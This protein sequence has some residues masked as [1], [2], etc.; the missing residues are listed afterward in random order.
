M[1]L[2]NRL[3]ALKNR[4]LSRRRSRRR[5]LSTPA[6]CEPLEERLLLSVVANSDS[7]SFKHDT[8]H[9]QSA[10][11]VLSN[12]INMGGGTL[13]AVL[14]SGPA[15]AVSFQLNSDGSFT[16]EPKPNSAYSDS[17]SYYATNG[18]S[19][20][21]TATVSLS[22]TNAAPTVQNDSYTVEY[23]TYDTAA[24]GVSGVL[25]NDTDGD[26]DALTAELLTGPAHG[27][28]TLN[29]DGHFI[30]TPD[31]GYEGTDSFE[32]QAGDGVT[33]T[34]G[35][36]T[37]NVSEVFTAQTNLVDRPSAGPNWYGPAG[38]SLLTGQAHTAVAV[39]PGHI[40][41]YDSLAHDPR[42]VV[43]VDVAWNSATTADQIEARLSLG[44]LNGSSVFYSTDGL[45]GGTA[46]RFALQLDA[47]TL[48]SGR[49]DY[50]LTLIAHYTNGATSTRTYTGQYELINRDGSE[51]GAGWMLAELDRLVA[52]TGGMLYVSGTG[53]TGWFGDNGNGTFT[54]PVGPLHSTSLV[55]NAD[56]SY[57]LKDKFGNKQEFNSAGLLTARV[58]T[59]G[60]AISYAWTDA[61]G[62][63][64]ADELSTI[65]DPFSRVTTFSYTAGLVSSVTD[66][67]GRATT[68]GRDAQDRL[69][70]VT[71]P[72]PRLAGRA[73]DELR[74]R[75]RRSDHHHRPAQPRHDGALRLRRPA[76]A[77]HLRRRQHPAVRALSAPGAGGHVLGAGLVEQFRPAVFPRPDDRLDHQ[78]PPADDDLHDGPLRLRY[79]RNQSAGAH[80]RLPAGRQ[81]LPHAAHRTR[82][83]RRRLADR[84][85][86]PIPVRHR[87]QSHP[88]HVRRQHHANVG[89]RHHAEPPHQHDG[90]AEPHDDVY[91]RGGHRQPADRDRSAGQ[92]HQLRTQ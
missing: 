51:F 33:T 25:A 63:T 91:L 39:A 34:T 59:N 3:L 24:L 82:P 83:G 31:A 7:Y 4:P 14:V 45:S 49:Y 72:D 92:D 65:T 78:S 32:Y 30:Y 48:A 8:T 81:R 42:P 75:D 41:Q 77:D 62:D 73:C 87:R 15:E 1:L 18:S 20:S 58:D 57:A 11:G 68:L 2:S 89:L 9:N 12:D 22:I 35:T 47:S 26:G 46:V 76:G 54:S 52:G 44:G 88:D 55:R 23:D 80:D 5:R 64:L 61:D 74:L 17:F 50:E 21:G 16:Y 38:T 66:H 60:N 19:N 28:L 84:A 27:S 90:R 10:P 86:H 43:A 70:S 29:S 71:A 85:G 37:L 56:G 36:V 67:A 40:L 53:L 13:T 69:T 79:Q 6:L